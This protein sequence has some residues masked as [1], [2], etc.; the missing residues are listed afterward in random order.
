MINKKHLTSIFCGLIFGFASLLMVT[1][2]AK[3]DSLPTTKNKLDKIV[4][5]VNDEV[6]TQSQLDY[7]IAMAKQQLVHSH[8]PT[9]SADVIRA[10]V[11]DHLIEISLQMQLIKKNN[12]KITS[13]E[14]DGAIANIASN[15]KL[16]LEQFKKVLANEKVSYE[17]FR[18]QIEQQMLISRFQQAALGHDI[19]VSEEEVAEA[20]RTLSKM[21]I[22]SGDQQ[23]HIQDILVP[24]AN[25]P[26][27]EQ[28]QAAKAKAQD[29]A[30]KLQTGVALPKDVQSNDLDWKPLGGLPDLFSREVA[31][32]AVG[33]V[34]GP[35]EAPN[36]IHM[37][38]VLG[39]RGGQSKPMKVTREQAQNYVFARKLSEKS[40]PWLKELR[41]T[42][43]V[44]I[45]NN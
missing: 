12:F 37:L 31:G 4:A 8:A 22:P 41:A 30:K 19:V 2:Q 42:A 44:K 25:N 17:A 40:I 29:L 20:M 34:V 14:L 16:S 38:K 26:T 6:I 33:E 1:A 27:S 21:T 13:E 36:G 39:V 9:P 3:P 7:E 24:L 43:Y 18:K 5:I 23:Y 45:V 28:I 11:L 15:N 32:K 10:K 35:I